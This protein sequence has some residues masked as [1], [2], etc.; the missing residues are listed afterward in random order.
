M[1]CK[2]RKVGLILSSV[3]LMGPM[4]N[5][6]ST[7][8]GSQQPLPPLSPLG[9]LKTVGDPVTPGD[10]ATG[11]SQQMMPDTHPLAGVQELTL[12]A[13]ASAHNFILPSF[14]VV[15]QAGTN[16]FITGAGGPS[17]PGTLSTSYLSGRL[18]LNRMS[19]RSEFLLDYVAGGSFSNDPTQGNSLIQGLETSETIRWG[20]WSLLLADQFNYLANSPF[21]FGGLGGLK[22]L[23][24]SLGNGV[25][26][27]PGISPSFAPGQSIYISGTPRINNTGL[28]QTNYAL[29]HRSSLTFVGSYTVLKFL[30][31]PLPNSNFASIQAGYDYLLSRQNSVSVLY[32]FSEFSFSNAARG[33]HDQCIQVAFARRITGRLSLQISSGPSIQAY[34]QPLSGSGIVVSPTV[35]TGLKY[36]LRYTGFGLNY[37]HGLTN[38]SG[39]LPG[40]ETDTFSG[41]ISRTFGRNWNFS[42]DAGYSRNQAIRQTLAAT[43]GA[44]PQTWFTTTRIS[45]RFVGYGAF[46]A[47]YNASGQSS[48]SSLCTLPACGINSFTSTASVGYTWGL[49]PIILE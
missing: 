35:S 34:Q 4:A 38:G 5:A 21:G 15:T 40:A 29:S 13:S 28:G 18:G 11:E 31:G 2:L 37:T 49:R 22:N 24:V 39:I 14:S 12:G 46:F 30:E 33:I 36:Q 9:P 27:S 20:R 1:F 16:P 41:T 19:E 7:N 42:I 25:G 6:Q 44:S 23:G 17:H 45:R 26:S 10:T 32:R 3:L 8:N 48:L 43:V 47:G